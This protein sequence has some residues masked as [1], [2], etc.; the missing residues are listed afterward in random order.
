M[1]LEAFQG[2]KF[3]DS[4]VMG[5][6]MGLDEGQKESIRRRLNGFIRLDDCGLDAR[7]FCDRY[8]VLG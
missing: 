2:M 4:P 3:M 1:S 7:A 8:V 5:S 6:T